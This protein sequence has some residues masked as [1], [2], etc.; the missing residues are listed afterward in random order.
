MQ[1]EPQSQFPPQPDMFS[2]ENDAMGKDFPGK[3]NSQK[4]KL[5]MV[6]VRRGE[7]DMNRTR[8]CI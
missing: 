2:E 1:P 5:F 8:G 6:K 7:E 3:W 4:P